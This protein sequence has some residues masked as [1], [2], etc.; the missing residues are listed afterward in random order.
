LTLRLL[1]N[2]GALSVEEEAELPE[3][4]VGPKKEEP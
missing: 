3:N 1:L 4:P 2:L